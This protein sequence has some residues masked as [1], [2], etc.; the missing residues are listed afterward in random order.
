MLNILQVVNFDRFFLF[1]ILTIKLNFDNIKNIGG[2]WHG[3]FTCCLLIDV[4][5]ID[6]QDK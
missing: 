3:Y 6:W 2:E 5:N 4:F 1:K